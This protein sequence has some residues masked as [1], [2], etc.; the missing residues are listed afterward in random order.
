[1]EEMRRGKNAHWGLCFGCGRQERGIKTSGNKEAIKSIAKKKKEKNCRQRRKGGQ[2]VT[3]I[4]KGCQMIC[5]GNPEE[6][7]STPKGK[8]SHQ[9]TPEREAFP[10]LSL[11]KD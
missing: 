2:K 1:M 11:E 3:L 7:F 10:P 4:I 9:A 8:V 6:D 5:R